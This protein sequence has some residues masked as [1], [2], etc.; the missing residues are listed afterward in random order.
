MEQLEG[1]M[2]IFDI[3]A[4][5]K[6]PGVQNIYEYVNH[7]DWMNKNKHKE[8]EEWLQ[9]HPEDIDSYKA[10]KMLQRNEY[11][12][13]IKSLVSELI[14][15][16]GD[17]A[18]SEPFTYDVWEH[19]PNLGARLF[20]VIDN[21]TQW[22]LTEIIARYKKVNLEIDPTGCPGDEDDKTDIYISTMWTTPKHK[23]NLGEAPKKHVEQCQDNVCKFSQ[24]ECNKDELWKVADS[25]DEIICPHVCCRNCSVRCC[26]ARCNGSREPERAKGELRTPCNKICDV[27]YGSLTC[28]ERRGQMFDRVR[29]EWCRDSSGEIMKRDNR[30]CDYEVFPWHEFETED[31]LNFPPDKGDWTVY[32]I[33]REYRQHNERKLERIRYRNAT[34]IGLEKN[35]YP[36][37]DNKILMWREVP[38]DEREWKGENI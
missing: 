25:L 34:F 17:D 30:E 27:E 36:L 6:Y 21:Q 26:G 20:I 13:I 31:G 1:Q 32:E 2:S 12:A 22:D 28:F 8:V 4:P 23:E 35:P 11:P 5:K 19:V 10:S 38:E 33:I 29:R 9:E 7:P 3:W 15:M 14:E 16:F 18:I 24:H 37:D